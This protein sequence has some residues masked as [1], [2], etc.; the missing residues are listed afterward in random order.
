MD[1]QAKPPVGGWAGAFARNA[2]WLM[3]SNLLQ[4][5]IGFLSQLVLMRLLAPEDFGLFALVMASTGLVLM[6]IA[7][8]LGMLVIRAREAEYTEE[9]RL[10]LNAAIAME[11]VVSLVAM[12]ACLMVLGQDSPWAYLLA[13]ILAFG[14]WLGSVSMFFERNMPYR[15]IIGLESGSQLAGHA[16]AVGLALAGAGVASLY[17]RELIVVALRAALLAR[18][19]A[20]PRWR[21]RRL[22]WAEWRDLLVEVR[23]I[24]VDGIVDGG[25]QRL[26]VLVAGALGGAHGAGLFFQAQRLAIVPHQ[27]LSPVVVR[28]A[29]N[30]FSRIEAHGDRRAT[31]WRVAALLALPLGLASLAVWAFASPLVPWLFGDKWSDAGHVLEAMAG[32][33]V[34]YSLF[35]L[36]R[37]YCL[38][39]KMNVLLLLGRAAQYGIFGLGC[40]MAA[41]NGGALGLGLVVSAAFL[42]AAATLLAGLAIAR[43]GEGG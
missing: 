40:L 13:V 25:F 26:T 33:V 15:S 9:F 4:L 16:A 32:M 39:Q 1:G 5:V 23:Y 42:A 36:G 19:G 21:L 35:E 3:G 14:H 20:I 43:E 18:I 8:R 11:S 29:G 27:I 34:G 17:L 28:L 37:A 30:V 24:W 31:L 6:V 41:E 22:S 10:R 12:L 2:G 38:A 7:P